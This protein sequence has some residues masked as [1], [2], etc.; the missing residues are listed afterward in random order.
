MDR[1]LVLPV[2]YINM[3][4]HGSKWYLTA[5]RSV[6]QWNDKGKLITSYGGTILM[7]STESFSEIYHAAFE[8]KSKPEYKSLVLVVT[9]N[10]EPVEILNPNDELQCMEA[11]LKY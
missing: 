4:S 10:G 2:F 3:R 8:L 1:D 6:T 7:Q 9:V 11:L 5:P